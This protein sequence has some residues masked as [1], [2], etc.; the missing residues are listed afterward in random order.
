[1][2]TYHLEP[3]AL[4]LAREGALDFTLVKPGRGGHAELLD[5]LIITA[6][7]RPML[8]VSCILRARVILCET[9]LL[10]YYDHRGI[11]AADPVHM[12]F[13]ASEQGAYKAEQH[14]PF[15]ARRAGFADWAELYTFHRIYQGR[16]HG[17]GMI[18]ELI[19]W[20]ATTVAQLAVA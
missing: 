7:G 3:H 9:G 18:R 6:D 19:A 14:L 8:A 16:S 2:K 20:S 5:D 17:A 10:R 11:P 1:M 13:L 15:L 4:D 12:L